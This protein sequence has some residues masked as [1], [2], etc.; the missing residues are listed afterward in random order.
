M[1]AQ[2]L[3]VTT[4][5]I[6]QYATAS[7]QHTRRKALQVLHTQAGPAPTSSLRCIIRATKAA[8]ELTG[9]T[10]TYRSSGHRFAVSF[11]TSFDSLQSWCGH[12]DSHA[13]T[14]VSELGML[15]MENARQNQGIRTCR[16]LSA[17]CSISLTHQALGL[18]PITRTN[19]LAP[20]L[21]RATARKQF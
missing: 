1:T 10:V 20:T 15:P 8:T 11:A 19:L 7:P 6:K 5:R 12:G 17:I 13:C 18:L 9:S 16:R 21:L 2:P 4:T 14:G 3:Y